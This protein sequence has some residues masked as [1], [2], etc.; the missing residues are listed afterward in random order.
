[1]LLPILVFI[2]SSDKK[3]GL[4]QNSMGSFTAELLDILNI[5]YIH[6][7]NIFYLSTLYIMLF[8]IIMSVSEKQTDKFYVKNMQYLEA[9][10]VG[11]A[12]ANLL[13]FFD[14]CR[15]GKISAG[16]QSDCYMFQVKSCLAGDKTETWRTMVLIGCSFPKLICPAFTT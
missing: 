9:N 16:C 7:H 8:I 12:F 11:K 1:M 10:W 14:G 3:C 4:S 13:Y 15:A 2:S 5:Y 6:T